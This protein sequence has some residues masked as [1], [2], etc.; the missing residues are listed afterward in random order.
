MTC[1]VML[2]WSIP[3]RCDG[4]G[5]PLVGR[6]QRWCGDGCD[7]IYWENHRWTRAREAA[8]ARNVARYEGRFPS[9][10]RCCRCGCH[11]R[12]PEVNHLRQALGA[13]DQ[14][15]CLHHQENLEVLCHD[16]HLVETARQRS[17]YGGQT[18]RRVVQEVLL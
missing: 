2:W 14:E 12:Y 16:C 6:Q 8:K 3:G 15:S 5:K 7:D 13:H 9:H 10:W 4:C 18:S 11:T 17:R 1:E